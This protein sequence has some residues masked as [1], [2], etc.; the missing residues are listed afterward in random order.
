MPDPQQIPDFFLKSK[1]SE[2]SEPEHID[3]NP[4][5]LGQVP[6][7]KNIQYNPSKISENPPT[8]KPTVPD[9]F[10]KPSGPPEEPEDIEKSLGGEDFWNKFPAGVQQFFKS[11]P[12]V[13]RA[14]GLPTEAMRRLYSP[15]PGFQ[16]W[17]DKQAGMNDPLIPK[18]AN[19]QD[20]ITA[21]KMPHPQPEY[22]HPFLTHPLEGLKALGEGARNF[23]WPEQQAYAPEDVTVNGIKANPFSSSPLK[24]LESRYDTAKDAEQAMGTGGL[25]GIPGQLTPGNIL[26]ALGIARVGKYLGPLEGAFNTA[27]KAT[28][29]GQM[30]SGIEDMFRGHPITGG[31]STALG[32]AGVKGINERNLE[33]WHLTEKRADN[34]IE[35]AS[36][37]T[38]KSQEA[39]DKVVEEAEKLEEKQLHFHYEPETDENPIATMAKA[40]LKTNQP[41]VQQAGLDLVRNKTTWEKLKALN[42]LTSVE[43]RYNQQGPAGQAIGVALDRA[44]LQG[45][46]YGARWIDNI[47]DTFKLTPEEFQNAVDVVEGN[48]APKSVKIHDAAETIQTQMKMIQ[49]G[50]EKSGISVKNLKGELVP[51][52][53]RD[54]YFPHQYPEGFWDRPNVV[55]ELVKN[56]MSRVDAQKYVLNRRR[57]GEQLS[58]FQYQRLPV[59]LPG[60]DKTPDAMVKYI[61]TA[62]RRLATAQEL[63]P[64]DMTGGWLA[65]AV[66]K[67]PNPTLTDKWLKNDIPFR[68]DPLTP[69]Q[70]IGV[71]AADMFSKFAA[72][73]HLSRFAISKVNSTIPIMLRSNDLD[74]AKEMKD[75]LTKAGYA[76]D[77][78]TSTG[79]THNIGSAIMDE[80]NDNTNPI[81]LY[82][83]KGVDNYFRTVAAGTGKGVA[84]DLFE[85]L[86]NPNASPNIRDMERLRNLILEDPYKVLR[87][88]SLTDNQINMAG[89]RF[90]E[91]T[92]GLSEARKVPYGFSEPLLQIPLIFKKYAFQHSKIMKDAIMDNPGRNIPLA[93]ALTQVFGEGVGDTKAALEALGI[94]AVTGKP[95]GQTVSDEINKRGDFE[96]RFLGQN[97][98]VNHLADNL[99]QSWA[100]GVG[101]DILESLLSPDGIINNAAGIGIQDAS[102]IVGNAGK[103]GAAYIRGDNK[104]GGQ[105][106]GALGR[107]ILSKTP[108]V[109]GKDFANAVL[110]SRPSSGIGTLR[111]L[112]VGKI[113]L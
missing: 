94:S 111:P 55:D 44:S 50:L 83:M 49:D 108:V 77:I 82:G 101:T 66:E 91:Q 6:T 34:T 4:K 29:Y 41:D 57:F 70:Q 81:G 98:L 26:S 51:F 93:L 36:D 109:G 106:A 60:Y 107:N 47:K 32:W 30:F 3:I 24:R 75:V 58:P 46:M 62:A 64:Q 103:A 68:R 69:N 13:Q 63:G 9:F 27:D 95:M 90:A 112:N 33:R 76:H 1:D 37:I 61:N 105:A 74:F 59:D 21:A 53:G 16:N 56:G 20:R 71:K 100:P 15:I 23:I 43:E 85:K 104:T 39:Q 89:A 80:I 67:T 38:D 42:P 52:K 18:L 7:D 2:T 73:S 72:Y 8:E 45:K 65:D 84:K 110:P 78:Q 19:E 28:S 25:Q 14:L 102:K 88:D 79:V 17:T 99:V 10:L 97:K 40:A 48:A 12:I 11:H 22:E 35:A 31:I 92:Q 87:Q 54:N 113:K 5:T 86:K 96:S